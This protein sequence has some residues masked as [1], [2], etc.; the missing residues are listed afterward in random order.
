MYTKKI[1]VK[2]LFVV[3]TVLLLFS[4]VVT[5]VMLLSKNEEWK[6][7]VK[8]IELLDSNLKTKK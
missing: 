1:S 4:N 8:K 2:F 7:A 3:L 6:S 5:Y